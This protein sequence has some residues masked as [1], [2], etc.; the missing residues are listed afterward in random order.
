MIASVSLG[1]TAI[2]DWGLVCVKEDPSMTAV[3]IWCCMG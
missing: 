2:I 3:C 1:C